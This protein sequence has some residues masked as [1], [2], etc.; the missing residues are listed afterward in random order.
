MRLILPGPMGWETSSLS[1][2]SQT[3]GP[4]H[5]PQQL[6]SERI[7]ELEKNS[8]WVEDSKDC[9]MEAMRADL[10]LEPRN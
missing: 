2:H 1:I 6:P 8:I 5:I 7:M 4:G 9:P 10:N 3:L